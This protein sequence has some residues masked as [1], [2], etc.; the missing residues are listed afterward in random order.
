[1]MMVGLLFSS[2][3]AAAAV[4]LIGLQ[5]NSHVQWKKV[6]NVFDKFC[7]QGAAAVVLSFL[8]ASAFLLLAML[9]IKRLH[10]K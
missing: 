7:H 3:G 10:R 6:C 1:M 9:T 5:G 8:G 2:N 4:G